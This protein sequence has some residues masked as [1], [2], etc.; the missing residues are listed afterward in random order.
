MH[1][2]CASR[3]WNNDGLNWSVV[4]GGS[5][6]LYNI[7]IIFDFFCALLSP[8]LPVVHAV[9]ALRFFKY[10]I[11]LMRTWRGSLSQFHFSG[12]EER[13]EGGLTQAAV[14]GVR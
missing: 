3:I 5:G 9:F 10:H 11:P 4:K 14:A 6:F 1:M 13:S 12:K 2:R 8:Y 7:S